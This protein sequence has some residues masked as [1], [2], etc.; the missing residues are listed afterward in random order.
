[1]AKR[2]GDAAIGFR[3]HTGW[4]AVVA[5]AGTAEEPRVIDRRRIELTDETELENT[6]VYHAAA[7][8]PFAKA[9]WMI[10]AALAATGTKARASVAA[11][12]KLLAVPV[13]CAGLVA[14]NTQ[15][16]AS[17][18]KVLESHALIHAAEGE[19]FRAAIVAACKACKLPITGFA[20]NALSDHARQTLGLS[21]GKLRDRLAALG[22]GLGPPWGQDQKEA[23]LVAWMA[24]AMQ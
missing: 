14:G 15:L 12:V 3:A 13:G 10:D 23:A 11:L 20:G 17:L 6:Q 1:M 2:N 22:A 18:E 5:I 4:A 7:E 24:L 19:M 16:P 21:P 9:E 8:Q